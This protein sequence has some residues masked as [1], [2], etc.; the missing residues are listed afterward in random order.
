MFTIKKSRKIQVLYYQ[1]KLGSGQVLTDFLTPDSTIP[2]DG[3][4]LAVKQ[5]QGKLR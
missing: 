4:D 1:D 2:N 5:I 3:V